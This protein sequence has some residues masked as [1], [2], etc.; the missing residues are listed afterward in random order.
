MDLVVAR[1]NG[2]F[3]DLAAIVRLIEADEMPHRGWTVPMRTIEDP[4]PRV[5]RYSSL[6]DEGV[7]LAV[8]DAKGLL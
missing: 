7:M 4:Q 1:N 6:R 5:E 2:M 8:A 3:I